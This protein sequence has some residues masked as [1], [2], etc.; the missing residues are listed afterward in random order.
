MHP[1][2]LLEIARERIR[3]LLAEAERH[4]SAQ[5]RDVARAP[6]QTSPRRESDSREPADGLVGVPQAAPAS[7]HVETPGRLEG[8]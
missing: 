2:I 5:R 7:R 6:S 3:D 8:C 1:D 4:R